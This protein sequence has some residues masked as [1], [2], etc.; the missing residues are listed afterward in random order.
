MGF[1][2]LL[3][4]FVVAGAVAAGVYYY[5]DKDSRKSGKTSN[6]EDITDAEEARDETADKVKDAATRA[7]TTIR[8][9][10]ED[11]VSKVKEAIGPNGEKIVT[12]AADTAAKV[13][14]VVLDSA[15]KVKDIIRDEKQ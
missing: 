5:L 10:T 4:G 6:G 8:Q 2:K 12:T 7:Y 3:A 13:R 15:G 9:T 11:T 14:D 1:G